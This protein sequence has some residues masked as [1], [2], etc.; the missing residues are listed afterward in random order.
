MKGRHPKS[1]SFLEADDR[2]LAAGRARLSR[3]IPGATESETV[4]LALRLLQEV[5]SEVIE[6]AAQRLTRTKADRPRT[7]ASVPLDRSAK[8]DNDR[9]ERFEL[10]E[11]L[12]RL[13]K[14]ESDETR[15][16]LRS[17]YAQLGMVPRRDRNRNTG[18]S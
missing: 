12:F 11:E 8:E 13:E 1:F 10:L 4:R 6:N 18:G 16:R 14:Q 15:E 2:T 5:S 17:L 9:W 7:L 3:I